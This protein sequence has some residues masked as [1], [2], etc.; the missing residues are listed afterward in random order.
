L[1]GTQAAGG[2][3]ET[4]NPGFV[5]KSKGEQILERTV[6][7][8]MAKSGIALVMR[9][10]T[11]ELLSRLREL[12]TGEPFTRET[13]K[14]VLGF[15]LSSHPLEDN[16]LEYNAY[17]NTKLEEL[18]DLKDDSIVTVGGVIIECKIKMSQKNKQYAFITI[19]DFTDF[20]EVLVFSDVLEK[21]KLL[22]EEGNN[23]FVTG[24]LSTKEGEKPKIKAN[25]LFLMK[26]AHLE[27]PG[28][29]HLF[30]HE[31]N[32][33]DD[34]IDDLDKILTQYSGKSE[35]IFHFRDDKAEL[36]S[37]STKFKIQPSPEFLDVLAQ[38]FGENSIKYEI[39]KGFANGSSRGGRW[40]RQS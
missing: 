14:K 39:T 11:G 5:S 16:R 2:F 29:L 38:R 26:T 32:L 19:Q 4:L 12:R 18:I 1:I 3:S 7:A 28:K 10:K 24:V 17:I 6:N 31:S 22:L 15:Y 9:P 20:I 37:M 25:D 30:L 35:V 40:K 13:E 23:I 36:H 27:I 8:H 33:D 21:R 34:K